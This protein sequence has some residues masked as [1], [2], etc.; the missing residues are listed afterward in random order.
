MVH[1]VPMNAGVLVFRNAEEL[2]FAGPWEMLNL[3]A[4]IAGGPERCLIV[5]ESADPV[6][7]ANGL[8]INPHVS[9]GKCP[10]LDLLLVPGG[11]GTRE[12]VDNASLIGFIS[13]QA[14]GCHSVLSVCTGAFLLH[15]AGLLSGKRATTHRNSLDRLRALGDVT[16]VERRFVRDGRIWTAAG[17][18]A[19]MDLMLAFIAD[20][21]GEEA[22][23]KVQF[24]AEYFPSTTRYGSVEE[25]PK[26]PAYLQSRKPP[27]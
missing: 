18:S 4:R 13:K 24:G 16:V 17:V 2:D 15:R 9:F 20:Y 8:S 22:A 26:A 6:V 25:H 19:G 7:C 23:A 10:K 11:Q 14:E 21:S 12:Q 3:W 1:T 27:L 5:A